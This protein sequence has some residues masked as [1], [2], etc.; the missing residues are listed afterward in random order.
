[1]SLSAMHKQRD[2]ERRLAAVPKPPKPVLPKPAKVPSTVKKAPPPVLRS[3]G[4]LAGTSMPSASTERSVVLIR[5][6]TSRV[7]RH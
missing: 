4:Q 3:T 7:V 5:P 6:Q 2:D 1:M